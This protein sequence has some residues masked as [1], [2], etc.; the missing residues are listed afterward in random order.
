MNRRS[1]GA[2]TEPDWEACAAIARQHGRSFFLA[3]RML[4]GGRRR[5]ILSAYAYCRLADDIVDRP[6]GD[7]QETLSALEAWENELDF[8]RHPVAVAF[9]ETRAR[10]GI[11]DQPVRDLFRGLQADLTTDRYQTWQELRVYCYQVAGTVGLIVAPIMG[12][13]DA[14]A[15]PRAAELGIAMQLTNILRD[16]GEDAAMGRVY[17]P[18]DDLESFGICRDDILDGAPGE[19]FADLLRFEIE[20]ARE[21]YRRA[22]TAVPALCFSGRMTTLAAARF[23]AGILDQIEAN[24]YD[25]LQRRAVV[26]RASKARHAAAAFGQLVAVSTPRTTSNPARESAPLPVPDHDTEGRLA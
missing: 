3:S 14:S 22:L 17:L 2:T 26:P 9:A 8:P 19:A 6:S 11:S 20:R 12:C 18:A 10:Y 16:V 5:A 1:A 15:L 25:V 4:G 21:L 7:A 23:Y 24:G 13:Q